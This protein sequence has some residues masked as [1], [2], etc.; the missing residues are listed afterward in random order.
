MASTAASVPLLQVVVE[1]QLGEL[2]VRV[3]PRNHE[4]GMTLVD[5]PFDVRVLLAQ[6]EDVVLIDPGRDDQEG[7][8]EH[9]FGGR[10]ELQ[11]LHQLVLEH[12]LAGRRG[13]VLAHL[14]GGGVGH[15]DAQLAFA[16]LHV[17]QQV[18]EPLDQVL[19]VTLERF[20]ENLRIGQREIR[21]RERVDKLAREE[22]HLLLRAV[23]Q[24]LDLA[25]RVMDMARRDEVGL[26]D[27]VKK[28]ML[29]PLLVPEAVVALGRRRHGLHVQAHEA[30]HGVLPEG[31]IVPDQIHLRL[32]ERV[33]VGQQLGHHFHESLGDAQ[34]VAR[35]RRTAGDL[36]LD[37]VG[38]ELRSPLRHFGIGLGHFLR[39][40]QR[41][42]CRV[43]GCRGHWFPLLINAA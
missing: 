15:A 24:A 19:T 41:S 9:L 14:E 17:A 28:K 39:I 21:W 42:C 35:Y 43:F 16:V 5:R 26:L 12:H 37:V 32:R 30:Q 20:A 40:G 27:E 7:A 31:K 11:Q 13:D 6:V 22:V 1:S 25:H 23:G 10:A 18:V 36:A 29:L 4:H 8:L 3:H 33:R 2:L 38:N 34:L